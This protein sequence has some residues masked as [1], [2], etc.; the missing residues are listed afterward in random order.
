MDLSKSLIGAG[1]ALLSSPLLPFSSF[2]VEK[3]NPLNLAS[4]LSSN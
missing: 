1:G 3:K 2:S 4:N